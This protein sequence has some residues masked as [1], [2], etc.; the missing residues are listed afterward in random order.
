MSDNLSALTKSYLKK[1]A[2]ELHVGDTVRVHNIVREGAKERIQ[3][4][5]GVVIAMKHGTGINGTFTVRKIS[6][7]IGVERVF[8]L[9]SPRIVKVERV[10]SSDTRRAKLYYLRGL[11]G[12]A[13]RLKN[14]KVDRALW[15]EKGAEAEIAAIEEAV[16]EE[17]EARAEEKAEHEGEVE[18]E[19]PEKMNDEQKANIAA[20]APD[21][22][23]E[24][25]AVIGE[26]A[27]APEHNEEVSEL[28][29]EVEAEEPQA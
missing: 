5:E 11:T 23:I 28:K 9:H 20:G 26:P 1:N 21:A 22:V 3:V 29:A 2:P 6:F 25:A 24:E 7:G 16:A 27:D 13:A 17:A 4:F 19:K 10:K 8:P 15:E 18:L 14:E 12:K